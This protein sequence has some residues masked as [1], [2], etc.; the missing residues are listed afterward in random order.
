AGREKVRFPACDSSR[1]WTVNTQAL[2]GE[3]NISSPAAGHE[4]IN[5]VVQVGAFK[6]NNHNKRKDWDLLTRDDEAP[7]AC[8]FTGRSGISL[9]VKAL[10]RHSPFRF[11]PRC[12]GVVLRML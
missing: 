1:L 11:K 2:R 6:E 8:T 5:T 4:L 9:G 10:S 12:P 7:L 3:R